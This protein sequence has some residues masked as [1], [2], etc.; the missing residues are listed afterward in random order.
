MDRGLLYVWNLSKTP[1]MMS[2][3]SDFSE[4]I[5]R[6]RMLFDTMREGAF[7]QLADGSL[8][9]IN[10][11]ALEIFGL[12]QEEFLSR[13]SYSEGWEVID[14]NHQPLPPD[15]HPSMLALTSG[16]PVREMILAVRNKRTN[17]FVWI[18]VNAIPQFR[19]NEPKP[20]CVIVTMHNVTRLIREDEIRDARM[21]ILE[22]A[23]AHNY[24][25]L[26]KFTLDQ[27]EL[28]TGS[29][30]GF[31]HFLEPDQQT[32]VLQTWSTAT[33]ERFCTADGKGDHY[34]IAQAG[35]WADCVRLCKPIIHNDYASLPAKRGMP[36]GHAAVTREI[37]VPVFRG[38]NIVAVLGVGNKPEDYTNE[39]VR[40]VHLFADLAW[41]ITEIKRTETAL[42]ESELKFRTLFEEL[43]DGVTLTYQGVI[44]DAN[45]RMATLLGFKDRS[46]LIGR[47]LLDFLTPESRQKAAENI[48]KIRGGIAREIID[49]YTYVSSSG[50]EISV[51]MRGSVIEM[52]GKLYGLSLQQ[53]IT[54]RKKT[55]EKLRSKMAELEKFN[56]LTVN[57]EIFMIELKKEINGLLKRIGEPEKYR[58]VE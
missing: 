46:P 31:F 25:E 37:V 35:V 3:L 15:R 26:L 50:T 33:E 18:I 40:V 48:Q 49:D 17:E 14:E 6:Y 28:L 21:R 11:A 34:D 44:V 58:I 20:Y 55:E 56:N 19:N 23:P 30:I 12:S 13:N 36:P 32:L 24:E 4:E 57:R 51:Q 41:D 10:T 54:E 52:G 39:D 22:Y 53:D 29:S 38:D 7:F 16:Q 27:L 9:T 45:H 1:R 42:Q 43:N 8:A 47:N 2:D 5:Q